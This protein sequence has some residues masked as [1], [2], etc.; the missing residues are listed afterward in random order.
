[1]RTQATRNTTAAKP[2]ATR[3]A[4]TNGSRLFVVRP[5][6]TAWN[7]R[8]GD[9]LSEI[10]SDMGGHEG[11]SEGQRQM[12]RRCA[13][14]AITCERMEN[15]AASTGK[16]DIDLYGT[17]CDRLGRALDRIGLKRVARDIGPTLADVLRDGPSP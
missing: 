14:L 2:A 13:T 17:L 6:D 8:F 16:M 10:I 3:S 7:R 5:G 12:A 9:V 4:V 11:L 15:E 1:M